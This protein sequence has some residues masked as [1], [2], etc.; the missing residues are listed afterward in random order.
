MRTRSYKCGE[1]RIR[2][3][4]IDMRISGAQWDKSRQFHVQ[5]MII[6]KTSRMQNNF[7]YTKKF[8]ILPIRYILLHYF[9]KLRCQRVF[10][11]N[12]KLHSNAPKRLHE[13]STEKTTTK[14][15]KRQKIVS[16][17]SDAWSRAHVS[18]NDSQSFY[19]NDA[20]ALV[21][22]HNIT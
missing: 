1:S 5:S 3:F 15:H 21:N 19:L 7:Q 14:R 6:T 22:S 16:A 4:N 12:P 20:Y 18:K 9:T 11:L 10:T 2:W 17:H 13:T 8:Q